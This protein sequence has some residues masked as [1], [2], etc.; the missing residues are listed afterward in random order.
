MAVPWRNDFL[1][2]TRRAT[3]SVQG[4]LHCCVGL[5]SPV[6]LTE[7]RLEPGIILAVLCNC[8][9]IY[10]PDLSLLFLEPF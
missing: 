1:G 2:E 5:I 4:Y 8:G 9:A 6:L 10:E 7:D 3:I